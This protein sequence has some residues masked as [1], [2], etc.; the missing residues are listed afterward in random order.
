M[1]DELKHQQI[2]Q[3]VN[4]YCDTQHNAK[5][6]SKIFPFY[7]LSCANNTAHKYGR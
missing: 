5:D 1:R 6:L 4:T 7:D 2:C 3:Y